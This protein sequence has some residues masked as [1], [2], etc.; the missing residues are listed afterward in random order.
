MLPVNNSEK[1]S[2]IGTYNAQEDNAVANEF[3]HIHGARAQESSNGHINF[4]YFAQMIMV[5]CL[6]I[7]LFGLGISSWNV[8]SA[9]YLQMDDIKYT[10]SDIEF[11]MIQWVLTGGMVIGA[12]LGSPMSKLG[13]WKSIV[14]MCVIGIVGNVLTF[15]YTIYPMLLIGKLLSGVAAG[16]INVFCPKYIME[17]S[18]KEVSGSAGAI[19]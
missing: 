13:R 14:I 15:F 8:Q 9:I 11:K 5:Q 17:S 3:N 1:N 4:C 7:L 2:A 19:F 6:G 12:F 10:D 18:P 16:G